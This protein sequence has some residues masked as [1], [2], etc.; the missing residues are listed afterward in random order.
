MFNTAGNALPDAD[1]RWLMAQ[2]TTTGPIGTLSDFSAGMGPIRFK[3]QLTLTELV[4]FTACDG[5]R[6][7][8]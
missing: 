5:M 2:I 6:L 7:H 1:Q 4:S 3:R 8:G